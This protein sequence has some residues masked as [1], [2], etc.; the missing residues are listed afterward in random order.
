MKGQN[1]ICLLGQGVY[2]VYKGAWFPSC[3]SLNDKEGR[4]CVGGPSFIENL[5][6][7]WVLIGLFL[8]SPILIDYIYTTR[9][10]LHYQV[11]DEVL[12]NFRLKIGPPFI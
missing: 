7:W 10:V 8:C 12:A 6:R 11:Y 2:V 5:Q 4:C 3:V 9:L 1:H